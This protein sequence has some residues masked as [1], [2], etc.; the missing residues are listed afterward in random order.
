MRVVV[1]VDAAVMGAE[2][3]GSGVADAEAMW[4]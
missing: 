3:T 2:M 4:L 1:D